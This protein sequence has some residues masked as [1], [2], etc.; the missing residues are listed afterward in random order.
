MIFHPILCADMH[1]LAA[2]HLFCFATHTQHA[3]RMLDSRLGASLTLTM[4]LLFIMLFIYV[5]GGV[6][7]HSTEAFVPEINAK[8][9]INDPE[10]DNIF[11][12]LSIRAH[13]GE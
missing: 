6:T 10:N 1:H 5:F 7:T 3:K 4:P 12:S 2:A 11:G 13:V 9:K 8:E